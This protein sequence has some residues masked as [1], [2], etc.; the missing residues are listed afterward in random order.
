MR[1][2]S[3]QPV[4]FCDF[5]GTITENDNIVAIMKH[6]DPE[7]AEPIVKDIIDRVISIREGVGRMFALLPTSR[8]DEIIDYAINNA[9]IRNGFAELLAFCREKQIPFYVT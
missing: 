2:D 8:Q 4:I 5:D 1:L 3:K 9:K 7:G 6:F